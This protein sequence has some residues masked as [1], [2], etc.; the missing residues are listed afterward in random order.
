MLQFRLRIVIAGDM[1]IGKT[2]FASVQNYQLPIPTATSAT[3]KSQSVSTL[4]VDFVTAKRTHDHVMRGDRPTRAECTMQVWDTAGQE[5]YRALVSTYF[6]S[7]N[8]VILMYSVVERTS[9]DNMRNY[10]L[11]TVQREAPDWC[12]YFVV[13]SKADLADSSDRY[14]REVD[15]IEAADFAESI[16]AQAFE[17]DSMRCGGLLAYSVLTSISQLLCE[18]AQESIQM[19]APLKPLSVETKKPKRC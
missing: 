19:P 2:E 10:W 18:T 8:A 14:K 17:I 5:K 9:F 4:G 6:R 11:P 15:A 13:G 1:G 3:R 7:A 16:G 12:R